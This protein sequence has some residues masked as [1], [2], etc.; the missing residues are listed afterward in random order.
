MIM[1]SEGEAIERDE[2]VCGGLS[3][4]DFFQQARVVSP[5]EI[6]VVREIVV[7]LSGMRRHPM[8]VGKLRGL[9]ALTRLM[10]PLFGVAAFVFFSPVGGRHADPWLIS[11][12]NA[13]TAGDLVPVSA[14]MAGTVIE[15]SAGERQYVRAGN[16]LVKLDPTNCRLALARARARMA[17]ANARARDALAALANQERAVNAGVR[18]AQDS[19][20]T[21]LRSVHQADGLGDAEGRAA[22]VGLEQAQRQVAD[23]QANV[24]RLAQARASAA[25]RIVDRDKALLAE[26]AISAQQLSIDAGVYEAARAE[27][28]AADAAVRQTQ[29]RLASPNVTRRRGGISQTNDEAATAAVKDAQRKVAAAEADARTAQAELAAAQKVIDRD[30]ALLA[31][32]AIPAQQLS[33][34]TAAYGAVRARVE[35][36]SAMVQQA[37]AQLRSAEAARQRK[38]MSRLAAAARERQVAHVQG[39]ADQAQAGIAKAQRIADDLAGAQAQVVDAEGAVNAAEVNL[40]RTLVRAPV[41]GWVTDSIARPGQR[42]R[43][44]GRLMSLA[45]RGHA[46]AI[47]EIEQ[48]QLGEVRIG[49][50]A[51]VTVDAPERRVLRGRVASIGHA[52]GSSTPAPP[53]DNT[54]AAFT[55]A[56]RLIPVQIVFDASDDKEQVPPGLP[57]AV[58]IDT[59]HRTLGAEATQDRVGPQPAPPLENKA[60]PPVENK[61]AAEQHPSAPATGLFRPALRQAAGPGSARRERLAQIGEQGRRILVRLQA[62]SAQIRAIILN[63]ASGRQWGGPVPTLL[64]DVLLRPVAGEIT[65]GYGWRIHPIFHTPEF[66]TGIDIA[67]SWGTPVLAPADGAVIF[68]GSMPANGMLLILDHGSGLSTT[69]SHLSSYAV[70]LGDRVRRGQVI[71]RIGST[72]WST[73]PHLFFEVRQNGQPVNPLGP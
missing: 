13:H 56:G 23:A 49:D 44:G 51:R 36:A 32:G 30:K 57:A 61:T 60:A 16:V 19:A 33:M 34:N 71:A 20:H 17:A 10:F 43:S 68:A 7:R 37:R 21:M 50:A 2:Q 22:A 25:Q 5:H 26:G 47:A 70:H 69:Y 42:V 31:D 24:L 8:S 55:N 45:I 29:A 38:E 58:V 72:G 48:S 73:G 6:P 41:G 65:S 9:R 27:E 64:H 52:D 46:W 1:S 40:G 18:A 14:Q 11:A 67:A 66:H 4:S 28:E 3:D 62:E 63:A 12:R 39:L 35:T 54:T 15:V 53:P 59:R